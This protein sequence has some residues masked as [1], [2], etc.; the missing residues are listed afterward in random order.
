[1]AIWW[2]TEAIPI[3]ATGLLPLI[4]FPLTG[5][6]PSGTVASTYGSDVIFLLLGAF[7]LAVA[8]QKSSLHRRIALHIVQFVGFTP[9][10]ILLGFMIAT[11]FSRCGYR[12][13]PARS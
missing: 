2:V 10:R 1:M 8:V 5:I 3:F 13:Q 12:I 11:G 4:L 7:L 6:L 9:S